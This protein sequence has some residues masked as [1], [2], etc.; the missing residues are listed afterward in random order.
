MRVRDALRQSSVRQAAVCSLGSHASQHTTVT[1]A[2]RNQR[3]AVPS[4]VAALP[5]PLLTLAAQQTRAAVPPQ[6]GMARTSTARTSRTGLSHSRCAM[7]MPRRRLA[8]LSALLPRASRALAASLCSRPQALG[9]PST[10]RAWRTPTSA[11]RA[12]PP[13]ASSRRQRRTSAEPASRSAARRH[14]HCLPPVQPCRLVHA[15]KPTARGIQVRKMRRSAQLT[16]P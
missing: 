16:R 3:D 15:G 1:H 8:R 4:V 7:A 13:S 14:W 10:R 12:S 6:R 5:C 9:S 2:V 11:L